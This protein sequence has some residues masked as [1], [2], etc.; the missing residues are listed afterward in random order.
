MGPGVSSRA[1]E[2]C[3][4]SNEAPAD[5][6]VAA[7]VRVA[8]A[9]DFQPEHIN[10]FPMRLDQGLIDL[11]SPFPIYGFDSP[12]SSTFFK[13]YLCSCRDRSMPDL[14]SLR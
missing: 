3:R 7:R 4:M 8:V 2:A 12:F 11:V 10:D 14:R 9:G 1:L 6:E 5:D 13:T